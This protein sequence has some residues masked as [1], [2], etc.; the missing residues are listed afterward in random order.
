MSLG[1]AD[2]SSQSVL[3]VR[4]G[5]RRAL[6]GSLAGAVIGVVAF[7]LFH[8]LVYGD[9][10]VRRGEV[11]A[12]DLLGLLAGLGLGAA[13]GAFLGGAIGDARVGRTVEGAAR[14]ALVGVALA[15]VLGLTAAS[16][17][18]DKTA[19]AHKLQWLRYGVPVGV[20]LGA[21]VGVTLA[22]RVPGGRV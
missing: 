22:R 18:P 9:A 8:G 11:P 6:V 14:G 13:A 19:E 21:G 5:T 20:L 3:P 16:F 17:F 1:R 7:V 15:V 12:P 4:P 10:A 2:G